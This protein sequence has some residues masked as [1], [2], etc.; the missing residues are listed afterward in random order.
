M[1]TPYKTMANCDTAGQQH[2]STASQETPI[3][4][5]EVA[6]GV[7]VERNFRKEP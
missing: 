7:E 5:V 6:F 3:A 2:S 1:G 4:G